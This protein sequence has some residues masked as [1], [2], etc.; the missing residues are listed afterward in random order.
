VAVVGLFLVVVDVLVLLKDVA[1]GGIVRQ[2]IGVL[3]RRSPRRVPIVLGRWRR[4][5]LT[6]RRVIPGGGTL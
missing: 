2:S 3:Q 6:Y 5:A 4:R 1:F